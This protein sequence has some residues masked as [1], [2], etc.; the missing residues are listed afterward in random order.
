V[1]LIRALGLHEGMKEDRRPRRAEADAPLRSR[2]EENV[3]DAD[4]DVVREGER[5]AGDRRDD[6]TPPSPNCTPSSV[7]ADALNL[8]L[9]LLFADV[10][11]DL[12]VAE[13][14]FIR[15]LRPVLNTP[16]NVKPISASSTMR[17]LAGGD[18]SRR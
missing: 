5:R 10:P 17:E 13:E 2:G 12:E 3:V 11:V 15:L 16:K 6:V 7:L 8:K 1:S 14:A 9:A 4:A 18:R